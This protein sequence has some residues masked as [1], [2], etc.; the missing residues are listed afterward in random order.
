[1]TLAQFFKSL[2]PARHRP[3][4]ELEQL[5]QGLAKA[6]AAAEEASEN[7][8]RTV[9]AFR[10]DPTIRRLAGPDSF[11]AGINGTVGAMQDK[12]QQ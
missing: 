5:R 12:G 7:H 2:V 1:M 8:E 10:S 3:D 6:K 11:M 4:P 9:I